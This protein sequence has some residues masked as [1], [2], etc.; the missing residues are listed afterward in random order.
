MRRE[1]VEQL[2]DAWQSGADREECFRRLFEEMSIIIFAFFRKRGFSPEECEDLLQETFL[3]AYTGLDRFRREVPFDIWLFEVA[4]NIYRKML[5]RRA[6]KKRK[7][8][9]ISLDGSVPGGRFDDGPG[10]GERSWARAAPTALRSVLAK[11]GLRR[12][13]RT[14]DELPT[15]MRRC[16]RLYLYHG[17]STDQIATILQI[18]PA[19]VKV[20]LFR[21]RKRFRKEETLQLERVEL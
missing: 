5:R 10:L 21:A 13:Y 12:C 14:L 1:R 7:G 18:S 20:Q 17:Y 2:V 15:Q 8:R 6:A 9:E 4:T 3:A 16:M 19:T 11:E